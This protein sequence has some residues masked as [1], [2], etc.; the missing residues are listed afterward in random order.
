MNTNPARIIVLLLAALFT[1]SALTGCNSSFQ[2][3]SESEPAVQSGTSSTDPLTFKTLGEAIQAVGDGAYS[4]S[5]SDHRYLYV[6]LI[7][8]R[9]YRFSADI[10]PEISEGINAIDFF[11]EEKD[12]KLLALIGACGLTSVEDLTAGAPVQEELDK[13]IGST[14]QDLLDSGWECDGSYYNDGNSFNVSMYKDLY[15]FDVAFDGQASFSEDS[16]AEDLIPAMTVKQ[17]TMSGIS[18]RATDL[19]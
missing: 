7:N 2:T 6:G 1:L 13:L 10:T 11:D 16:E 5:W 4:A 9:Y 3:S 14:G 19:D 12:S 17:I 8:D 18:D 15:L